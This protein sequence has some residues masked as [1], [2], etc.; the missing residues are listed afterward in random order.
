MLHFLYCCS[1][2]VQLNFKISRTT[3][4]QQCYC[5][6]PGLHEGDLVEWLILTKFKTMILINS[7]L[8]DGR[9]QPIPHK[10]D[11]HERD[12]EIMT[13][14]ELHEFGLALLIVYLYK[15]K[16]ELIRANDHLGNE[17]PHLTAKNPKGELLYIWVKT[18]MYPTMPSVMSIENHEEVIKLSNQ[19]GAIPVFAGMRMK[20]VSNEENNIPV[21]GAGYEV[22]FTGF[23]TF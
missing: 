20:C 7:T 2:T 3:E 18:E 1:E 16:G 10:G 13:N 9:I 8:P 17:Y 19:F 12:G 5:H 14:A 6:S 21:Y 22:E 23:K 15:Q 4:N 11:N